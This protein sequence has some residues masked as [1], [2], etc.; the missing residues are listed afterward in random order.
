MLKIR[1]LSSRF[2]QVRIRPKASGE[3]DPVNPSPLASKPP[4]FSSS[5]PEISQISR[6]GGFWAGRLRRPE[7]FAI[8]VYLTQV[9]KGNRAV[10]ISKPP[11]FS[12]LRRKMVTLYCG[13]QARRRRERKF[14][15]LVLNRDENR[16]VGARKFWILVLYRGGNRAVGARIFLRFRVS[17]AR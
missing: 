4:L 17:V 8:S 16:A 1:K 15:I 11:K 2:R 10:L 13:Y 5:D 6:N 7:N 12:C 9:L 3:F 14:W